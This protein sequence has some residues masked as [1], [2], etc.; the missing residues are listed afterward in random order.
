MIYVI[1]LYCKTL[2]LYSYVGAILRFTM[3]PFNIKKDYQS[4][5]E[6]D[7][8]PPHHPNSTASSVKNE[9][10]GEGMKSSWE[11]LL[12]DNQIHNF[13]FYF[14]VLCIISTIIFLILSLLYHKCFKPK[15]NT[16]F[17]DLKQKSGVKNI[18]RSRVNVQY[19]DDKE[20]HDEKNSNDEIT[21]HA[22]GAVEGTTT[23]DTEHM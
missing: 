5:V 14:V 23:L 12:I 1:M 6:E 4:N 16:L 3:F 15:K 9:S 17:G 11:S 19:D 18:I 21:R 2:L 8:M 7:T 22:D 10:D 13:P 20:Y